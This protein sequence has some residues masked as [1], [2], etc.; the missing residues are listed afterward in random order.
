MRTATDIAR[1]L[2]NGAKAAQCGLI[3]VL[4]SDVIAVT[5]ALLGEPIDNGEQPEHPDA[6]PATVGDGD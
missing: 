3:T 5:S 6:E 2:L 1:D 4:T